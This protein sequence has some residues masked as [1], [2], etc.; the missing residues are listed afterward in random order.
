MTISDALDIGWTSDGTTV[1][2]ESATLQKMRGSTHVLKQPMHSRVTLALSHTPGLVTATFVVAFLLWLC[3]K[4]YGNNRKR[5]SSSR[6]RL[7]GTGGT[8]SGDES[9][10]ESI[11]GVG[12]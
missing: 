8:D 10:E 11:C 3:V 6:R 12:R 4:K 7:S 9:E 1:E 5:H 2:N